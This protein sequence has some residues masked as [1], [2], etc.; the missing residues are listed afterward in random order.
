MLCWCCVAGVLCCCCRQAAED[1]EF[2]ARLELI[3]A[4]AAQKKAAVVSSRNYVEHTAQRP[5]SRSSRGSSSGSSCM[6]MPTPCTSSHMHRL[7]GYLTRL[8]VS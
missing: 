1:A 2:Q 7:P 5:V 4:E 8:E 3:K 6:P